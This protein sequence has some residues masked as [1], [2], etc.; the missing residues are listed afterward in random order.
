[1]PP[2]ELRRSARVSGLRLHFDIDRRNGVDYAVNVEPCSGGR[3]ARRHRRVT[4]QVG[5]H[6]P[7]APHEPFGTPHRVVGLDQ[8]TQPLEVARRWALALAAG[9]LPELLRL[10]APDAVIHTGESDVRGRRHVQAFLEGQDVGHAASHPQTWR[11]SGDLVEFGYSGAPGTVIVRVA[12]GEVA[13]LW[14]GAGGEMVPG[15]AVGAVQPAALQVTATGEVPDAVVSGARFRV[16]AVTDR[17]P[18][19]VLHRRLK[20]GRSGD[21]AHPAPWSAALSVDLDGEV[22]RV[23]AT[24]AAPRDVIDRLLAR[25]ADRL[26]HRSD[27]EAR[28]AAALPPEPGEWRRGFRPTVRQPYADRPRD[29]R[30]LVRHKTFLDEPLTVE[31]AAWDLVQLDYD[32]YLFRELSTG[33][34]AA[35]QRI[36]GGLVLVLVAPGGAPPP[37]MGS[38][39][40]VEVRYGAPQLSVAGAVEWL[41]STGDRFLVFE[42]VASGRGNLL[43][44]RTDGHYGLIAPDE[45]GIETGDGDL[46]LPLDLT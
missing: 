31:E 5:S 3:A 15:H 38:L 30:E 14:W 43:Y 21:P 4:D 9:D 8:Q 29:E 2:G 28:R 13:E 25:L 11:G 32:A 46:T 1:V 22:I 10:H 45:G 34:D 35:M 27:R 42:N 41:D 19:P 17:L 16:A 24:A 39:A 40:E 26:E 18:Q 37:V 23:S 6:V 36:D 7:D 44:R 12:H 20:L 33:H